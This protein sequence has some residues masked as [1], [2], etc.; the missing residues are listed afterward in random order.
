MYKLH[1][2]VLREIMSNVGTRAELYA[3]A[4]EK[5]MAE[6]GVTTP[7]RRA[8]FLAQVLHETMGLKAMVESFNYTPPAILDTFNTAEIKRFTPAMAQEYGRTDT[9]GAQQ[10]IIA[11]VAYANRMGNGDVASGDGHRF[12]GRGMFQL[13]GRDNYES[14]GKTLKLDLVAHPELVETPEV[15]ARSAGWFWLANGLNALADADDIVTVSKRI[16]G[17]TNGLAERINLYKRAKAA[18]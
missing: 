15:A 7:L 6:F 1:P 16:N 11:N 14:C 2:D 18:E 4:L 12:R 13:T 17:G 3:P 9:H 8:A 10:V 5:A